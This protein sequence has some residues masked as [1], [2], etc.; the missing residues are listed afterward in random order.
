LPTPVPQGT[1][2]MREALREMRRDGIALRV[3]HADAWCVQAVFDG[4]GD[5][6]DGGAGTAAGASLL[7]TIERLIRHAQAWQQAVRE[8]VASVPPVLR[9][10]SPAFRRRG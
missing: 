8:P 2:A 6:A 4:N 5:D 7:A 10:G 1:G 9:H 3:L